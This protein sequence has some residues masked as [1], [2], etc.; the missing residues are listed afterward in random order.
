[1]EDNTPSDIVRWENKTASTCFKSNGNNMD[2]MEP[3]LW[4]RK[5]VQ[6]LKNMESIAFSEAPLA[7][8]TNPLLQ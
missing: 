3:L 7:L 4:N 5:I 1:M 8:W 2:N 6:Q